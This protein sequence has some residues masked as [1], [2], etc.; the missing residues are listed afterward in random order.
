ML[1]TVL[2]G[3]TIIFLSG[4]HVFKVSSNRNQILATNLLNIQLPRTEKV[5]LSIKKTHNNNLKY[6][7]LKTTPMWLWV[8]GSKTS[9]IVLHF[10]LYFA[11]KGF[12]ET[13]YETFKHTCIVRKHLVYAACL[14]IISTLIDLD[15]SHE[16][17]L[18]CSMQTEA[19]LL[20]TEKKYSP[21]QRE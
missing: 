17:V 10:L 19:L 8:D 20:L 3:N 15:Q 2:T 12:I 13:P 7:S 4:V 11:E 6:V 16:S 9:I 18:P 5:V 1:N 14:N 21:I